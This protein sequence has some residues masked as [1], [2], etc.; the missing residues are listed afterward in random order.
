[1]FDHACQRPRVSNPNLSQLG[2]VGFLD[3]T[4]QILE[5]FHDIRGEYLNRY[6]DKVFADGENADA[7]ERGVIEIIE[8]LVGKDGDE[9]VEVGTFSDDFWQ[10]WGIRN[11]PYDANF[12]SVGSQKIG[13]ERRK[14][15]E[16]MQTG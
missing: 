14:A 7:F 16:A 11:R 6:A 13:A 10:E 2:K 1:M 9:R 4:H 8:V 12:M 15:L 5:W 3:L